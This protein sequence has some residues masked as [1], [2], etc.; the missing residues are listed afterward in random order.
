[1]ECGDWIHLSKPCEF[2]WTQ[3]LVYVHFMVLIRASDISVLCS[4]NGGKAYRI[5][6][7]INPI[8]FF[9]TCTYVMALLREKGHFYHLL[10]CNFP[11]IYIIDS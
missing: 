3:A 8:Y 6:I 9:V 11:M 4:E 7:A 10:D 1:M 5:R 2:Y